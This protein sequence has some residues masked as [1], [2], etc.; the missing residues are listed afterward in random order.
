MPE[1]K[2]CPLGKLGEDRCLKEQC[3]WWI[4]SMYAHETG[5]AIFVIGNELKSIAQKAEDDR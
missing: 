1:I 3:A 5:C 2:Y 4:D